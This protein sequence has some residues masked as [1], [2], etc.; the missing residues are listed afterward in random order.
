MLSMPLYDPFG[1]PENVGEM[2]A[3]VQQVLT[4]LG[5]WNMVTAVVGFML[6]LSVVVYFVKR[7]SGG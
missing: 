6:A 5:V 2:F 4:F 7:L 1:F 3:L